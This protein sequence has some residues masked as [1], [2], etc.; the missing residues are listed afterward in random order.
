MTVFV[1]RPDG[2]TLTLDVESFNTIGHVKAQIRGKEGIK[3]NL[4]LTKLALVVKCLAE[5]S[6]HV[7]YRESKLT[8]LLRDSL[9]GN[10][11]TRLV[12]TL[13]PAADCVDESVSTLR[14][15]DRARNVGA[16]VRRNEHRPI[17]HVSV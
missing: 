16:N 4:S 15:A 3:I 14:F 1:K 6:A 12:A 2:R 17:D 5:G 8:H 11:V 13:S 9:G 7:P 10:S